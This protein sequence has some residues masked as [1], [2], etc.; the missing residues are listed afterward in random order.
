MKLLVVG[1]GSIGVEENKYFY[2]NNHTGYFLQELD[3]EVDTEFVQNTTKYVKNH[4]L[5]NF[6]LIKH[7]LKFS[8]L[9]NKLNILFI[10]M[11]LRLVFRQ[12]V[13]YLFYPGNL[14]K[15]VALTAYLLGKPFGLYIRG[16]YY[17]EGV[18]DK[19][20]LRKTKFVLTVSPSIA[21]DIRY[22]CGLV[23]VIKPMVSISAKDIN[24]NRDYV[25]KSKW[26]LLFVGR[27]EYRKGIYELLE[28]ARL[29]K[30]DGLD[31][32]LDVVGGGDA[33]SAANKIIRETGLESHVK[34]HGL[35]SNKEELRSFYDNADL[36][37]FTSHDEGFPRVLYE[38]MASGM[39]I[40]TTFVG[41]ISGRMVNSENCFQIP[42]KNAEASAKVI[43]NCLCCAGKLRSV[44]IA[45]QA[46]L[47][48]ILC[49]EL[50]SHEQLL[51]KILRRDI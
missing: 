3:K 34:V 50:V 24:D 25:I 14:S 7:R 9:P 30:K 38:A 40:F 27:V 47:K 13:L 44:G 12:E 1:N 8:L 35:V 42:V 17:K 10:P 49:G 26:H 48:D 39:P 11:L 2:I 16:Q 29:L 5:Q 43:M 18:V 15:L 41:G 6:D 23:D 33:F 36:F 37:V 4:D 51:L 20:I 22:Y 21:E 46:T 28:I 32:V 45:G 31:F 19:F